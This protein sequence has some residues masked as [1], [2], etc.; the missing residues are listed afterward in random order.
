MKQIKKVISMLLAIACSVAVLP[1]GALAAGKPVQ[2]VLYRYHR[3]VVAGDPQKSS[4]CP[5]SGGAKFGTDLVLEYSD[6]GEKLK[7]ANHPYSYFQ[8][9][10][11]G[12]ACS[13]RGCIDESRRTDRFVDKNGTFWFYE[14]RKIVSGDAS[15]S[16]PIE[17]EEKPAIQLKTLSEDDRSVYDNVA[18]NVIDYGV[19]LLEAVM[20]ELSAKD[21]L[22][23][24]KTLISYRETLVLLI[25]AVSGDVQN[26]DI[27]EALVETAK[28]IAAGNATTEELQKAGELLLTAAKGDS[29]L[30]LKIIQEAVKKG[31]RLVI[32]I[33][34]GGTAPASIRTILAVYEASAESFSE[35]GEAVSE[36]RSV[37]GDHADSIVNHF[38]DFQSTYFN[39]IILTGE[40]G[41]RDRENDTEKF[42]EGVQEFDRQNESSKK[43]YLEE[44]SKLNTR[45]F[46]FFHPERACRLDRIAEL[47]QKMDLN[48]EE[49]YLTIVGR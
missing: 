6:W 36:Y 38:L 44:I 23:T 41:I 39:W 34:C 9:V 27:Q 47:I 43:L 21:R 31:P 28:R 35:L 46:K 48:F 5:Y 49:A 3:W 42:L 25:K 40:A 4:L 24:A 7:V 20:G 19:G 11:Q 2:T 32:S 10:H 16:L 37:T 22:D 33:L 8:H 17:S 29:A 30:T 13:S 26:E 1:T 18:A 12:K 14:E 15:S 45:I